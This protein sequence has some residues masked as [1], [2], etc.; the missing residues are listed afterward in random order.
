MPVI[1]ESQL[2]KR[3]SAGIAYVTLTTFTPRVRRSR[4]CGTATTGMD[5][6]SGAGQQN[7][8]GRSHWISTTQPDSDHT[9]C[10]DP[11]GL[12]TTV[13]VP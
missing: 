7:L 8:T 10:L 11:A 12:Q 9:R 2:I 13:P 4:S 5:S 6:A 3:A 1:R